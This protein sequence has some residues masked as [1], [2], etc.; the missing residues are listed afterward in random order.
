MEEN[1][2]KTL[3]EAENCEE[4]WNINNGRT[5]CYPCHY[6]TDNYGGACKKGKKYKFDLGSEKKD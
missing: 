5:L 4:L 6:K 2:I 1:N 3:E